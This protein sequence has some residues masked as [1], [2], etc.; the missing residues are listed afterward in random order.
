MSRVTAFFAALFL[1]LVGVST[2]SAAPRDDAMDLVNK[3]VA[4]VKEVGKEKALA[5]FS[6][7]NGKFV[8]GDLYIFAYTM[9]GVI[10]AHPMNAKLIGTDM[11]EVK[12]ANGKPFTKYFIAT[13][14]DAGQGWVDYSWP[15]P[16]T[17]KIESKSSYVAKAGDIFVGCGIYK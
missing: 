17:K 16:T 1:A 7:R 10:I 12:D 5:S 11:T 3:A 8:K 14:N 4:H 9:Q 13:V 6:D 2:V 15:N